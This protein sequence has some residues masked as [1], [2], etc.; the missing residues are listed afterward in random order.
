MPF[1]VPEVAQDYM[2]HKI[3]MPIIMCT[4]NLIAFTVLFMIKVNMS[5]GDL[6]CRMKSNLR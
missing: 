1:F 3:R 4:D 2:H 5:G 6:Q